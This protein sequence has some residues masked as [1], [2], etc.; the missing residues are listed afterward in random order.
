MQITRR[1]GFQ[2]VYDL[3][4]RVIPE[5]H[6]Q[7]R[8]AGGGRRSTGPAPRRWTGWALPRR[9]S[10]RPTGTRSR[11]R[12]RATGARRALA[13]GGWIEIEVEG[14]DGSLRH[15]VARP[16]VLGRAAAAPEPPARLRIL[17][18]FDPALR[19]RDRAERLFGFSYRIEVFVPEAKR[20]YGY[21]VFPLLEGDRIV[22]RIDMKARP[23]RRGC[24]GCARFW[25]EAGVRF[26][27][28]REGAAG[29]RAGPHG[30][31]CRLRPGRAG[32]GL[33][34]RDRPSSDAW[35]GCLISMG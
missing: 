24:C 9:A 29:G 20:R 8:T 16:D 34:P 22:G 1:D 3:T 7:R 32:P 26:G 12:R 30:A 19:D 17:S 4:E 2:K 35:S 23:R 5:A 13:R 14:A 27:A 11:P 18:P 15:S 21:Y 33:A 10:W 25:P 6:R 28:G 31:L